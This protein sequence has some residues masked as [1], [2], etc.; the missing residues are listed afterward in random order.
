MQSVS[1]QQ[2]FD[3]EELDLMVMTASATAEENAQRAEYKTDVS[4][5]SINKILFIRMK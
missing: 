1:H 5:E 4:D 3:D 2:L